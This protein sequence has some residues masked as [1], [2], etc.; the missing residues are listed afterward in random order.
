MAFKS[1][2]RR[3]PVAY[4][5]RRLECAASIRRAENF[6]LSENKRSLGAADIKLSIRQ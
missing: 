1:K 4:Y 5:V 2:D 6:F 3:Y